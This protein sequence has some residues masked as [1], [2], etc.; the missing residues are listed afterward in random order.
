M[1]VNFEAGAD[2]R[3][4]V[5]GLVLGA[6]VGAALGGAFWA[7][8]RAQAAD[9]AQTL[10][11]PV[12]AMAMT[13]P[14]QPQLRPTLSATPASVRKIN[15]SAVQ[16]FRM[17]A[18]AAPQRDVD[19]L[20]QAIYYEAR[21][22]SSAGQAAIAQ[23]VLNRVR[24]PAYPKSI[25]AVVFQGARQGSCQFS[26]ACHDG[27]S[28]RRE[29]A[30]WERAKGVAQRALAGFVMPVVGDATSFHVASVRPAW[31]NMMR[32]A[33][34]GVHVFYRF[35]GHGGASRF[36][37]QAEPSAPGSDAWRPTLAST[38]SQSGSSSDG[39]PTGQYLLASAVTTEAPAPQ[40]PT[41]APE[42]TKPVVVTPTPP[43]S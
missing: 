5:G 23:V 27:L 32:V 11:Q 28:A 10:R 18:G 21:G 40:P 4:L 24:H 14:I 25:C 9:R 7:G 31:G 41:P 42:P 35:G 6:S 15:A 17:A 20:T 34:I 33:Q 22:E 1:T 19:C 2:V 36:T 16:P 30:A 38:A 3:A 37:G 26:F 13:A 39:R 29:P 12:M 8:D 43:S